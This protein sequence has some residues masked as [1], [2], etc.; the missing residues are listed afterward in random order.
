MFKNRLTRRVLLKVT[1]VSL[2]TLMASSSMGF[3]KSAT[4]LNE[5]LCQIIFENVEGSKRHSALVKQFVNDLLK[6]KF[7]SLENASFIQK[8]FKKWDQHK[9]ERFVVTQYLTSNFYLVSH[10]R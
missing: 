10:Q 6:Q 2:G 7:D 9:L 8:E 1:G 3:A 4:G 5:R